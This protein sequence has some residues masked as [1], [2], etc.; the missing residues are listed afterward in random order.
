MVAGAG[1]DQPFQNVIEG[2]KL[3]AEHTNLKRCASIGHISA[4]RAKALK[5]AGIQRVHHNVETAES[6]YPEVS[7]T[8]RY[9]GR[10]RT[11]EAVKEA[12]LE[13]CVAAS[14]TSGRP[15]S[16]GWRWPSS[17]LTSTPPAS[18]STC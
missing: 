2:A 12:G 3:V 7:T 17:S 10:I 4:D 9:E 11:I 6:Y 13:T 15:R 14:S 5:E 16:S 1:P 18:R 8:V